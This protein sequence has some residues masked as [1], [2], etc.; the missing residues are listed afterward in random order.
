MLVALGV[1]VDRLDVTGYLN[2]YPIESMLVPILTQLLMHHLLNP[3]TA[4]NMEA[5]V[6]NQRS[7]NT[8]VCYRLDMD[9]NNVNYYFE[10]KK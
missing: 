8:Q 4:E 5:Y 6:K 2:L 9:Q 10:I 7:N 1:K 3:P